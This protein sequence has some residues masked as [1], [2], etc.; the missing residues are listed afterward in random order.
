MKGAQQNELL[1]DLLTEPEL[2]ELKQTSLHNGLAAL[3]ARQQRRRAARALVLGALPVVLVCAVLIRQGI[4]IWP[5]R[6]KQMQ[7]NSF[8]AAQSPQESGVKLINDDE[9]FALFPGRS[10]ALVGPPGHQELLFL[11]Q[12]GPS[13]TTTQ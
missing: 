5:S 10:L 13:A 4:R 7:G 11:D 2:E 6:V 12:S 9:L 3:R 1:R 8:T